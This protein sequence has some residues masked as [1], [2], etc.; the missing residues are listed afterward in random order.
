MTQEEKALKIY[1][2]AS[3]MC[4]Y[5]LN[6]QSEGHAPPFTD[7]ESAFMNGA[8]FALSTVQVRDDN[9]IILPMPKNM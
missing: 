2:E 7:F 5:Y 4:D 9:S 6:M 3:A 8:M 1:S